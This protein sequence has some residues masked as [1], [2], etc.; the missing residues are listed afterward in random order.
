MSAAFPP[1]YYRYPTWAQRHHGAAEVCPASRHRTQLCPAAATTTAATTSTAVAAAIAGDDAAGRCNANADSGQPGCRFGWHW[2]WW[3]AAKSACNGVPA[4]T[5]Q[6]VHDHKWTAWLKKHIFWHDGRMETPHGNALYSP[7]S[8]TILDSFLPPSLLRPMPA[9]ILI[10]QILQIHSIKGSARSASLKKNARG[11]PYVPNSSKFRKSE[12]KNTKFLYK[13][14]QFF[15]DFLGA[16][17]HLLTKIFVAPSPRSE[18][19]VPF[20]LWVDLFFFK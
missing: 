20:L 1:P 11:S 14:C 3:W 2:R 4:P 12:P 15:Q 19:L 9:I 7:D 16:D 17:P 18:I 13:R 5:A 6:T 8:G 10:I